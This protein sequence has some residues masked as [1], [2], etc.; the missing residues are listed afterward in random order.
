MGR[1][2]SWVRP[3]PRT[4]RPMLFINGEP[5]SGLSYMTYRPEEKPI[6]DFYEAGCRLFFF[7]LTP[8]DCMYEIADRTWIAPGVYDYTQVDERLALFARC[9]PEAYFIPRVYMTSPPWWD[10]AHPN[11]MVVFDDGTTVK[12]G[13]IHTAKKQSYPSLASEAWRTATVDNLRR[14]IR[15]LEDGPY[16]ERIAGYHVASQHTEEWFAFWVYQDYLGDYSEP[17]L[18]AWRD[19]LRRRYDSDA[20]LQAAWDRP[21]VSLATAPIPSGEERRAHYRAEFRRRPAEQ[22]SIDYALFFSELMVETMELMARTAKE[23]VSCEK[24]VGA[25]YGY[26]LQFAEHAPVSGHLATQRAFHSSWIDFFTSP[27]AYINRTLGTGFSF[28]MAPHESVRAAGKLWI[29]E[30]DIVTWPQMTAAGTAGQ[31][32]MHGIRSNEES[33]A[34]L[35]RELGNTLCHGAGMWWFDFWARWYDEPAHMAH[36]SAALALG[37]RLINKPLNSVAEVLL[38]VDEQ[39]M[40]HQGWRSL[41]GPC[42]SNLVVE[43]G[44]MG[45]PFDIVEATD[46]ARVLSPRH[47]LVVIANAWCTNHWADVDFALPDGGRSVIWLYAPLACSS[48]NP[49]TI[50]GFSVR[51]NTGAPAW[52]GLLPVDENGPG[53]RFGARWRRRLVEQPLVEASC[54][55]EI[56]SE[57]RLVPLVCAPAAVDEEG[58]DILART[59]DGRAG[60]A[61]REMNGWTSLWVA[62]PILSAPWLR[63]IACAA[64]VHLYLDTGDTVYACTDLLC[65]AASHEA[66][67]RT[68]RLPSPRT[69]SNALT[70][71][72]VQENTQELDVS[73]STNEVLVLALE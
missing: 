62:S 50:C 39:S 51:H 45:A 14:L 66:G 42:L 44:H 57:A 37:N 26:L 15:H 40:A 10:D 11:E 29:N 33:L 27:S 23:E 34:I 73:L 13:H 9:A 5:V 12:P 64:D 35:C 56:S 46:L 65:V 19:W 3:H 71:E 8:D 53:S 69:L 16:G 2:T 60:M 67:R 17:A 30:N 70:G 55:R 48:R 54:P 22:A 32:N 6:T 38:V 36:V 7:S 31:P 20:A 52:P 1:T 41:L 58:L 68:L 4:S 25:F 47:R 18:H 43:L 28:F 59:A 63:A 61:A 21:D 49:A 72:L 24:I